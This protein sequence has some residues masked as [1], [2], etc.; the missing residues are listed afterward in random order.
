MHRRRCILDRNCAA[1]WCWPYGFTFFES[2]G[3][4]AVGD[5]ACCERHLISIYRPIDRCVSGNEWPAARGTSSPYADQLTNAF[6]WIR[7]LWLVQQHR[8]SK[9]VLAVGEWVACC[10]GHLISLYRPTDRPTDRPTEQPTNRS[11]GG[12]SSGTAKEDHISS[13]VWGSLLCA[14]AAL[15]TCCRGVCVCVV[16]CGNARTAALPSTCL[17]VELAMLAERVFRSG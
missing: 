1:C 8:G 2:N 16:P 4:L 12:R 13:F 3:V 17:S 5:V 7:G 14:C 6:R 15:R 10:E 9:G 11:S